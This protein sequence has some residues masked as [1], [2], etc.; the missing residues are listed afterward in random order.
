MPTAQA[1][2]ERTSTVTETIYWGG[3]FFCRIH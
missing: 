2:S 1:E 3:L